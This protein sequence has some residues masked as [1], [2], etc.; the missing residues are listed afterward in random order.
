MNNNSSE[1]FYHV[2]ENDT[3]LGMI[4]RSQAHGN[5]KYIHRV[6]HVIIINAENQMYLQQRSIRK[7]VQPGKWD[8]AVGG[9]VDFGESYEA[10]AYREMSEELGITG[11][12]IQF[13]YKYLHR[14]DYESEYVATF[15]CIW[16]GLFHLCAEE[17]DDGRFWTLSEIHDRI[18][19][20]IFTPN[21]IDELHRYCSMP[22]NH[23]TPN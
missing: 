15:T 6:A 10:A 11:T 8:T 22:H 19:E 12:P 3:I 5:P 21:F 17:I 13:L 4:S 20:N 23:R 9:H 14:N 2:D 16:D 1:Q 7:T 18:N